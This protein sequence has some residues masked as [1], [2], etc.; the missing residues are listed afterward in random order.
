MADHLKFVIQQGPPD[1]NLVSR[2]R[3]TKRRVARLLRGYVNLA[4]LL[5][6]GLSRRRSYYVRQVRDVNLASSRV[7]AAYKS[8]KNQVLTDF[9]T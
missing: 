2:R 3:Q 6:Y 4:S 1:V 9:S 5:V 8:H 7:A